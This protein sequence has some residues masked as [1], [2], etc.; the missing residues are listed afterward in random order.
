[1]PRSPLPMH[2]TSPR[3]SG[4]RGYIMLVALI[5]MAILAILGV[6]TLRVAGIDQRV[7]IQNRKHML[8]V[9][10]SHAGTEHAR[11]TLMNQDPVNEG[12]DTGTGA[13]D[14]VARTTAEAS[15][16]G[17]TYA[18]NLGVYWVTATYHR[19]GN[20]P[21]GYSTELGGS[22]FRSDYW[23]MSSTA[24][25]QASAATTTAINETQARTSSLLRKVR[26]G[27]CKIR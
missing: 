3:R 19:C 2:R 13:G 10:T 8:T 9:N 4:Q 25:F 16:G 5:V 7:A 20:P 1:M 18:Q 23:E 21:P 12:L 14:F 27:S 24:R 17:L 11:S 26:F 6:T 15:F 22:K